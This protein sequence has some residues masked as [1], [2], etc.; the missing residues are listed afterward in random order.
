MLKKER[1]VTED[2]G[3]AQR[4]TENHGEF[5]RRKRRVI[6]EEEDAHGWLRSTT[7]GKSESG[8]LEGAANE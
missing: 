2:H 8:E 7:D 5:N 1:G 3:E 4:T 6:R